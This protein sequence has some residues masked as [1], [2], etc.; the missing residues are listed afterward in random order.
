MVNAQVP[1]AAIEGRRHREVPLPQYAPEQCKWVE[2]HKRENRVFG[3]NPRLQGM[4]N[5]KGQVQRRIAGMREE[6][7]RP[8]PE[9]F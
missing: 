1:E 5:E 4:K 3:H 9:Y 7:K 2:G 8:D 6:Q